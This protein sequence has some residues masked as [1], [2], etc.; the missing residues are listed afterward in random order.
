MKKNVGRIDR[1]A[2]III[3][4]AAIAVGVVFQSWW[5]ALGLIPLV[6]AFVRWCPAYSIF[7]IKT[8]NAGGPVQP[9][10]V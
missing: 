2:R 10:T 9:R 1:C 4:V 5:G 7:R 8:C 6:T 3:G